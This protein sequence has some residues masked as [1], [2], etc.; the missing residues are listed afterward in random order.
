[1]GSPQQTSSPPPLSFTTTTLPQISHLKI[2]PSFET[3]TILRS[4]FYPGYPGEQEFRSR[5]FVAGAPRSHTAVHIPEK[6]N[7]KLNVA[8][9]A[10]WRVLDIFRGLDIRADVCHR[11]A[12]V[13]FAG[14]GRTFP[15]ILFA[16]VECE[17]LT[18]IDA[19]IFAGPDFLSCI[20]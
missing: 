17:F 7:I 4:S 12:L 14:T 5:V 9:S 16:L 6:K 20:V 19:D 13:L 8:F 1:M 11:E 3:F 2:C 18:A 15:E 10:F